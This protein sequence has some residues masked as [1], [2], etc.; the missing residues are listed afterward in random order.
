MANIPNLKLNLI[1]QTSQMQET[2]KL[3]L[4]NLLLVTLQT[5]VQE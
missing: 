3:T 4:H 1:F 5:M 2:I